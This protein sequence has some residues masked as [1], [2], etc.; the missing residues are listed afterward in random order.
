[1]QTLL[2]DSKKLQ[3]AEKTSMLNDQ[4]SGIL[5][6]WTGGLKG[7]GTGVCLFVSCK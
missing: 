5:V 2:N 4:F 7:I 6:A 3:L 1:M